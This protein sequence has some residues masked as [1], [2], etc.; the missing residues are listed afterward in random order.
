[1]R[2]DEIEALLVSRLTDDQ[3]RAVKFAKWRLFDGGPMPQ[4]EGKARCPD[5]DFLGLCGKGR[6]RAQGTW[7]SAARVDG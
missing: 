4:A 6:G 2:A 7:C 5:C 1:M 3:K